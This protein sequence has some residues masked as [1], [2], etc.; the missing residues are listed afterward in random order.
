MHSPGEVDPSGK[1]IQCTD[2]VKCATVGCISGEEAVVYDLGLIIGITWMNCSNDRRKDVRR[3]M[4]SHTVTPLNGNALA[5]DG[6]LMT[7]C[8]QSFSS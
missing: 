5:N 8:S 6:V 2:T 7:C 1:R 4:I 3:V